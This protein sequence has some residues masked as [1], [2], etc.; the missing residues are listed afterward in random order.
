MQQGLQPLIAQPAGLTPLRV[1]ARGGSWVQGVG[2]PT[3]ARAREIHPDPSALVEPVVN[4]HEAVDGEAI[5]VGFADA[6]DIGH[7]YVGQPGRL[8]CAHIA[9]S[10]DADDPGG[11]IG[12]HE[13][14]I[15]LRKANV[16][17]R[18]VAASH[19]LEFVTHRSCSFKRL[20]LSWIRSISGL[21]VL[22]PV[23]D[24]FW[25]ASNTLGDAERHGASDP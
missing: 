19:K 3:V 8:G 6:G 10:E 16:P 13:L 5:Q 18:I 20:I 9:L 15:G 2:L 1:S 14:G 24:F 22:M 4:P 12:L 21:G 23:C 7:G 17:E 11:E 25:K